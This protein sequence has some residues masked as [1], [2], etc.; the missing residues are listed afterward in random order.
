MKKPI[1]PSGIESELKAATLR[2]AELEKGFSVDEG[3]KVKLALAEEYKKRLQKDANDMRQ[4]LMRPECR[5]IIYR[6]I[7]ESKCFASSFVP[8]HSD[9]TAFNEGM[10]AMGL[11]I[12]KLAELAEPGI[13]LKMARENDSD[14]VVAEQKQNRILKGDD[15]G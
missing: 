2:I 6:M 5:R 10:R 15:N 9:L 7:E 14:R 8:G 11:F 1:T 13:C 12:M 3:D 4:S